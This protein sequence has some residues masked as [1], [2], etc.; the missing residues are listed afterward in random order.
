MK[1]GDLSWIAL[2]HVCTYWRDIA[3]SCALLWTFI[4]T[5]VSTG[6]TKI[7]LA[8][9]SG[10]SLSIAMPYPTRSKA[11]YK[12]RHRSRQSNQ[13][14]KTPNYTLSTVRVGAVMLA[15]AELSRTVQLKFF[16]NREYGIHIDILSSAFRENRSTA[17]RTLVVDS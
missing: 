9:S 17:L 16:A 12:E 3:L 15:L 8:R 7:F 14:H 2:S 6:M 4:P 11:W 10:A 13:R 1:P 5:D